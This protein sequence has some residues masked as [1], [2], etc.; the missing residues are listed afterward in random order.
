MSGNASSI[1]PFACVMDAIDAEHRA[2]HIANAKII[3]N[4]VTEIRELA[5]G[6][7]FCFGSDAQILGLLAEFIRLEKRCCLFFGFRIE[8]EPEGGNIFLELTGREGVKPFI[9][10]E[11]SEIVNRPIVPTGD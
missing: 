9:R 3:F 10:A 5:N 6:Y 8:I 2:P 1:S 4:R 7:S 11:I